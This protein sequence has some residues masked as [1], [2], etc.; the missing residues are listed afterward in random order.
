MHG[1][2]LKIDHWSSRS[3]IRERTLRLTASSSTAEME[4][5]IQRGTLPAVGW[6][7]LFAS[8]VCYQLSA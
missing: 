3:H 5:R 7:V 4:A 1:A 6:S 8:F 2:F